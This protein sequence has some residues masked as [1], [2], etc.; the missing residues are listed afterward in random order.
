MR[1]VFVAT[2]FAGAIA[3]NVR[4]ARACM[5]DSLSRDE[6]PCVPQLLYPQVL[7]GD[8]HQR[9]KMRAGV[10]VL[11]RCEALAVYCDHGIEPLR[12]FMAIAESNGIPVERRIL[13]ESRVDLEPG[14]EPPPSE[15][16]TNVADLGGL[17][18]KNPEPFEDSLDA[19]VLT[20][21]VI[22]EG[23]ATAQDHYESELP[24][25]ED[26]EPPRGPIL[27]SA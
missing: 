26:D 14:P 25:D 11:K 21:D 9:T 7:G 16:S 22:R 5:L 20:R 23:A 13:G 18:V 2:P 10:S 19:G 1:V 12:P 6:A 17:A 15:T 24:D 4:Y 3:E 8:A 27:G